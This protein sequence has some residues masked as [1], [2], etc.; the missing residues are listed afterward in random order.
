MKKIFIAIIALSALV[1]CRSLIEEWQPVFGEPGP[2]KEFVPYT[3][4]NL[5]PNSP[6]ITSYKTI[7]ELKAM[8]KGTALSVYGNVWIKG[9][10]IS[11]DITGNIYRELYIQDETGGID[12]KLGKSSLYSEYALGQTLYVYCD[13]LTLGAYNGMPQLGLAADETS[14]NEY[15]TSYIDLQTIID[16]HVFKGS[17]GDPVVPT[18]VDE[19][20]VKA[21][22]SAKFT[23][24]LWGKLV[25]IQ[26][27]KYDNQI[28][29]LV[30]PNPNLPHKS[31]NPENRVFLSGST[32]GIKTWALSKGE[33][34]R[35]LDSGAWDQAEVGSGATRYGQGSVCSTV[36]RVLT[37]TGQESRL[38]AFGFDADL[39]YK[40]VMK[41]YATANYVSHYFKL[42]TTSIQVRTSGYSK[43]A[44]EKVPESVLSGAR[45]VDITGIL[46]IY[47]DSAQFSLIDEPAKSVKIN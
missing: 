9:K 27:L 2:S 40:E 21:A 47:N 42:G 24:E 5:P 16:Q 17:Y 41:K 1:S 44:D 34:I 39:T 45:T 38:E 26:G 3:D 37:G 11:S 32:W 6:K 13:D 7:K 35:M 23:G 43:F 28:F 22:L 25:T 8:Y 19:A 29:A 12:L 14:S 18:V 36:R 33:Y 30:Y 15:E 31:G 20:A 10:V 46:T 4:D